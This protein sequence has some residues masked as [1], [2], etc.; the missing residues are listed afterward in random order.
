MAA[1]IAILIIPLFGTLSI[2]QRYFFVNKHSKVIVGIDKDSS[3]INSIQKKAIYTAINKMKDYNLSIK[4]EGL[5]DI[6][7]PIYVIASYNSDLDKYIIPLALEG[8][9][10]KYVITLDELEPSRKTLWNDLGT[11]IDYTKTDYLRINDIHEARKKGHSVV[12]FAGRIGSPIGNNIPAHTMDNWAKKYAYRDTISNALNS[13]LPIVTLTIEGSYLSNPMWA[14]YELK[15]IPIVANLKCIYRP[16][17]QKNVKYASYF[18]FEDGYTE[19]REKILKEFSHSDYDY[20]LA[21][22]IKITYPKRAEG[23]HKVLYQ[24]INCGTKYKMTSYNSNIKCNECGSEWTLDELGRMNA[25][26]TLTP[27]TPAEWYRWEYLECYNEAKKIKATKRGYKIKRN[28]DVHVKALVNSNGI[29]DIGY[30][31]LTFN[32]EEFCLTFSNIYFEKSVYSDEFKDIK[33]MNV[34]KNENRKNQEKNANAKQFHFPHNSNKLSSV[35][36][37]FDSK[38]KEDKKGIILINEKCLFYVYCTQ[39]TF[40]PIELQ[41]LTEF[42]SALI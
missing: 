6:T 11:I 25:A 27:F 9:D 14:D 5:D 38:D 18:D 13:G 35:R 28:F 19:L 3:P 17:N 15:D 23:L 29:I 32:K 40:E 1:I 37:R 31:V 33:Y 2:I 8:Y 24:C 30:G 7:G 34:I 12:E 20:Q 41:I 26:D 10:P 16:N 39:N 21:N 42:Y 4:R 36:V 22:N